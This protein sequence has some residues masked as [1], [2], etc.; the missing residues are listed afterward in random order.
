MIELTCKLE[1]TCEKCMEDDCDEDLCFSEYGTD[2]S[3]DP[4]AFFAKRKKRAV[5]MGWSVE[6][7][8]L[9]PKHNL[10]RREC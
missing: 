1:L 2:W 7:Q 6:T 5:E 8:I 4:V 10:T 9:C 3:F